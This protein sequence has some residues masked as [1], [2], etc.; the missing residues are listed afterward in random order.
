MEPEPEPEDK[1]VAIV[2]ILL[3]PKNASI[4]IDEEITFEADPY[5]ENA[6]SSEMPFI[7][8][9]AD[10]E[11]AT[12]NSSG[13]VKGIKEGQT[14]I[15]VYAKVSSGILKRAQIIVNRHPIPLE[16]IILDKEEVTILKG[17][18]IQVKATP[19][20][21]DA[22]YEAFEWSSHN[23][24]VATVDKNGLIKGINVGNT[25]VTV[26]SG[27]IK[28]EVTVNIYDPFSILIGNT[29]HYVDTLDYAVVSE[30]I[31]WVKFKLP[32]FKNITNTL[33]QGLVVNALE[34]D[35]TNSANY[36]EVCPATQAI[37]ANIERPSQMMI[38]KEK[39][40]R[41]KGKKPVAVINGDFYLVSSQNNTGYRYVENRPYGPEVSNGMVVQTPFM[42]ENGFVI[43]D[44]GVP[45]FSGTIR[46][47]GT[48]KSGGKSFVL[49]E[50]NGFAKEGEMVLFNNLSNSWP[51]DSAFAWSPYVSTMVSLSYPKNGWSVNE[52]MEFEVI[53]IDYEVE[54]TIPTASPYKGKDFNGQG[55]IL[56]G[57]GSGSSSSK[58]FLDKLE[59]GDKVEVEMEL[60]AG[61]SVISGTKTNIIG[62]DNFLLIDGMPS[63]F[64]NEAHPRTA[65]GYSRD[66]KTLYMVTVDGRQSNW[67]VGATVGEVGSILA[68]LGAYTG[69][70]FDG[71]GSTVM[72]INNEIKN[73]PSDGYE[74]P[75]ANGIMVLV[76]Q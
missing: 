18:S 1:K 66:K 37:L 14:H 55:A 45:S 58:D 27:E 12:V 60:R 76:Q 61:N 5:P 52:T 39:E 22:N 57:N 50:V 21:I 32:E 3:T 44:D 31:K 56:V 15:T 16:A 11:I 8:E 25:T 28:S 69:V 51:T 72:V 70:N 29:R 46:F 33:G 10:S 19:Q 36:I 24:Q 62:F 74:R 67:S 6:D 23:E 35:L 73:K 13:L 38:R 26:E 49:T 20:P 48:V 64:W 4:L 75:V 68:A 59:I 7:W 42:K 65:V 54:T 34:V 71:G 17:K 53:D 47:D 63:N 2:D 43:T 30:G 9:S 41:S 40:Y